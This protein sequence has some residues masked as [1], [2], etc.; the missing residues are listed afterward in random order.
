M[1]ARQRGTLLAALVAVLRP[2]LMTMTRRD[3][4][5][6]DRLPQGG[7]VLAANHISYADPLL[8]AHFVNDAGI[9]PRFLAK[10]EVLDVPVLGRLLRATGQ[11]PV[12]RESRDAANALSAAVDAIERGECLI[13]YPEGTLTHDP[14]LWPMVGKTGAV[15]IALATGGPVVPVAQWGAHRILPPYGRVPRLLPRPTIQVS[16]G[17]PVDL[18]DLRGRPVTAPLLQEGTDRVMTAITRLLEDLRHEEAPT[19][20]FDPRYTEGRPESR[21]ADEREVS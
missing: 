3:W 5:G 4:R 10:A 6:V 18:D 8:L 2:P 16:A 12:Y 14:L 21:L 15:R 9:P 1:T 7:F 13:V 20:R 11:I 17:P 19:Q